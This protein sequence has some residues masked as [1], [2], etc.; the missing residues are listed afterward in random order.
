MRKERD[1]EIVKQNGTRPWDLENSQPIHITKNE[2]ACSLENTKCVAR[3]STNSL[4]DFMSR[5]TISLNWRAWRQDEVKEGHWTSCTWQDWKI[6]LF[7]CA[8]LQEEWEMTPRDR[9]THMS[10]GHLYIPLA[11]HSILHPFLLSY[12]TPCLCPA[13]PNVRGDPSSSSL[14]KGLCNLGV[15]RDFLFNKKGKIEDKLADRNPLWTETRSRRSHR[16][17]MMLAG[18]CMYL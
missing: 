9:S 18:S 13:F 16:E 15:L 17:E 11:S 6:E 1:E 4:W 14:Y 3:L 2:K 5:N 8:I 10:P 12:K 7:N